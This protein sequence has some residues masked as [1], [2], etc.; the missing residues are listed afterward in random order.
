MCA[1]HL[2]CTAARLLGTFAAT[3]VARAFAGVQT[4]ERM[5]DILKENLIKEECNTAIQHNNELAHESIDST[6]NS[7]QLTS[8]TKEHKFP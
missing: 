5:A 1:T 4:R 7:S 6:Q 2:F 3:E 8:E